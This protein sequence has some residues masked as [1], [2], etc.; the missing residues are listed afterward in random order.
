M[1]FLLNCQEDFIISKY[2][3][4][5]YELITIKENLFFLNITIKFF[6]LTHLKLIIFH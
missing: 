2:I 3:D 5:T 6:I 1:Y 4:S